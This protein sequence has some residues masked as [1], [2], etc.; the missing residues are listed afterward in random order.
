MEI[1]FPRE[2]VQEFW[3]VYARF[4]TEKVKER[5]ILEEDMSILIILLVDLLQIMGNV[6]VRER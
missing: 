1:N 3:R 6:G 2:R 5:G 4:K